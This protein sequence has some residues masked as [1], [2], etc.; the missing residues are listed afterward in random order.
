ML[1]REATPL[2]NPGRSANQ[3]SKWENGVWSTSERGR[4]EE[5]RRKER[6]NV[7]AVIH[8]RKYTPETRYDTL[9]KNF[10]TVV[11]NIHFFSR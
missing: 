11:I 1:A 6:K 3:T 9:T 10:L 8:M 7:A 5:N 4:R 2:T